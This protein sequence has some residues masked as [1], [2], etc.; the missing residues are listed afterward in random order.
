VFVFPELGG[1]IA[2]LLCYKLSALLSAPLQARKLGLGVSFSAF[3]N[4]TN[5]YDIIFFL[6]K[7][8]NSTR[9]IG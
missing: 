9:D 8:E 2:S 6:K 5:L 7:P 3:K 4:H 1:D